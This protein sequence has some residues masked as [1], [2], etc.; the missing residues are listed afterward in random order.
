MLRTKSLMHHF[1]LQRLSN[2]ASSGSAVIAAAMRLQRSPLCAALFASIA[3]AA[4]ASM[5]DQCSKLAGNLAIENA[6]VHFTE[7][8]AAGTNLTFPDT[9]ASCNQAALVVDVDICRVALDVATT[10]ESG[11]IMEAWL[12]R[13]WS[14]RFLTTGNG[15]LSG[16]LAYDTMA[17]TVGM[18]FASV[19]A[20]NGHNGS[21][22]VSFLN[23]PETIKDFAWRSVHTNTVVG[24]QVT[25]TFYQKKH[26]KS[27]FIGCSTGGRQG[28]KSA[29]S[30]PEDFDGI[31]AGAPALDYNHY[32]S[33]SSHFYLVTGPPGSPSY[34]TPDQWL[35][36]HA[37]VMA[38][39]DGLDGSVDGILEE[40]S[41]CHYRPESLLCP[42]GT[43]ANT[44]TCITGA[45]AGHVRAVFSDLH[46][47]GGKFVYPQLR[48]GAEASNSLLSGEPFAFALD[49]FT[50]AVYNGSA[51]A[52]ETMGPADWAFA[53][54]VNPGDIRTW[55]GDLS[56]ARDRGAK[57]LTYHGLQD[58]IMSDGISSRY[59]DY[60][61]RTM[62]LTPA[63]MD[64]FYRYFRISGMEHCFGGPG[65]V[66]FGQRSRQTAPTVNPAENVLTA[67]VHWVEDG[68][69]PDTI[70]GTSFVGGNGGFGSG[71]PGTEV[72]FKRRHCRYPL[73]NVH[74]GKGDPKDPDTWECIL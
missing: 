58:P 6:T 65:A 63:D 59:Y 15:G 53:D 8:V 9:D 39:C 64:D 10:S 42:P 3:V 17:Y 72:D 50:H 46:G 56:A 48:P 21:T 2:Q 35:A 34:L 33:W 1:T 29:Q 12:P 49:W 37:D 52:L 40:P 67:L 13:N 14:G 51:P 43:P 47:E 31:V 74:T 55:S 7:Y 20:N 24:K 66:N 71:T 23:S 36:V 54:A 38:Q 61:A 60:V 16:C 19:G 26:T 41:L 32:V 28:F 4:P 30:F 62:N 5:Q 57:I 11:I 25:E 22:G 44:S 68:T 73:R 27:Y 18:G 45:Q 69:T 70:M